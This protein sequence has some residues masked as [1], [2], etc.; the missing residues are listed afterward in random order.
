MGGKYHNAGKWLF[1][2]CAL[3]IVAVTL[4]PRAYAKYTAMV[5]G[6]A[7]AHVAAI[8]SDTD[9]SQFTVSGEL[10]PG[11][12]QKVSFSVKNFKDETSGGK[13][14]HVISEVAQLYSIECET[15]GNLP[16][17]VAVTAVSNRPD[18]PGTTDFVK[19]D[20]EMVSSTDNGTIIL[21]PD[22]SEN[23]S[24]LTAGCLPAAAEVIHTYTLILT[25]PEGIGEEYSQEIDA[26][27]VTIRAEQAA[28][29]VN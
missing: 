16:L 27:T 10:T 22:L 20:D 14:T 15:T 29:T 12:P 5:S 28:P 24:E 9:S 1:Y 4:I 13:S 26:V 8:V 11:E 18:S 2:L 6:A 21:S 3:S 23:K 19:K 25:M 7:V 17:T